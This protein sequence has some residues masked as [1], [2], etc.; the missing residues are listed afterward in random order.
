MADAYRQ[1]GQLNIPTQAA[2][3]EIFKQEF[4]MSREEF[5]AR[6]G[7]IDN[8]PEN[9]GGAARYAG[10]S[11]LFGFGDELEALFKTGQISG[12]EFK[13][14]RRSA[15]ESAN[16]YEA[17]NPKKALA[18]DAAGF[19]PLV[20][21]MIMS[22]PVSGPAA[23]GAAAIKGG[24]KFFQKIGP[25]KLGALMGLGHGA[26]STEPTE[27]NFWQK[28]GNR[29]YGGSDDAVTYAGFALA[30]T[31]AAPPAIRFLSKLKNKFSF[32]SGSMYK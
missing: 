20:A 32:K 10:Q 25:V 2:A 21:G 28:T 7:T 9:S 16:L 27:G 1:D 24:Q 15:I 29:L 4:G 12:E 31:K 26:G 23:I 17:N 11:F 3:D 14:A 30:L 8:I 22:A 13:Q 6:E 18:I 5:E 19:A